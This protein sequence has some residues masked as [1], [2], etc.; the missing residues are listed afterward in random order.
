M[1]PSGKIGVKLPHTVPAAL[2]NVSLAT[3]EIV[4]SAFLT[5]G[6]FNKST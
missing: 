6:R 3:V 5:C 4:P 1:D 2:E